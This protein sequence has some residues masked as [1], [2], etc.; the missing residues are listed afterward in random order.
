MDQWDTDESP[1]ELLQRDFRRALKARVMPLKTPV[2]I[3][4]NGLFNDL[5]ARQDPATRAW[6]SSVALFYKAGGIPWRVTST[7]PETCYIGVSFHYLK[8]TPM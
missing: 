5:V 4:T 2:Q 8:T 7:G 6:N 3:A 1:E